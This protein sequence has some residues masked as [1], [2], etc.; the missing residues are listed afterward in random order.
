V[1]FGQDGRREYLHG[2]QDR[3]KALE[4]STKVYEHKYPTSDEARGAFLW[5]K[6][7]VR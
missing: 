3:E 7:S 4:K 6:H 5:L 2:K 1:T